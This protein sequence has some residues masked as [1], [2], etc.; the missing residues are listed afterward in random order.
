MPWIFADDIEKPA[1]SKKEKEQIEQYLKRRK[2]AA[3]Y[4]DENFPAQATAIL[5]GNESGLRGNSSTTQAKW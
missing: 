5:K 4:A 2:K 3:V 1:L